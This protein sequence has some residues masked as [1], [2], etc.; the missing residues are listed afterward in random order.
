MM[1]LPSTMPGLGGRWYLMG[2][3]RQ[4]YLLGQS[5]LLNVTM[6]SLNLR[7]D[8][9]TTLCDRRIVKFDIGTAQ[10]DNGNIKFKKQIKEPLNV[11]E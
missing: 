4:W 6:E 3:S 5:V 2:S 7:K 10:R 9:G 1:L 8:K 11:T